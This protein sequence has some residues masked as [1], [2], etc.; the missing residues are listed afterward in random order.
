MH[1]FIAAFFFCFVLGLPG[2]AGFLDV[3][4]T[5][6]HYA[7]V[8]DLLKAGLITIPAD[9]RFNGVA[10]LTRYQMAY[11]FNRFL[12]D[13]DNPWQ[14]TTSLITDFYSDLKPVHA[15]YQTVKNLVE[16]GVLPGSGRF[17]GEAQVTR[18]EFYSYFALLLETKEGKPLPLAAPGSGFTDVLPSNSHYNYLRK[19][20]G[21]GLLSGQGLFLGERTVNRYEMADFIAPL[22]VSQS[23]PNQS[24]Q[25]PPAEGPG[26]LEELKVT[27]ILSNSLIVGDDLITRYDLAD[28]SSMI[29]ERILLDE[30]QSLP[31]AAPAQAYKD[32]PPGHQAYAA[33]QK[34]IAAGVVPPGNR[35]E[36]FYGDRHISRYQMVYFV[37]SAL[38]YVLGGAGNFPSAAA[39]LGYK[40]VINS[41][42]VYPTI[43]KLIGLGILAGGRENNFSG[44]DYVDFDELAYFTVATVKAIEARLTEQAKAVEY[45]PLPDF[46]FRLSS[47]TQVGASQTTGGAADGSDLLDLYGH[48]AIS[49]IIDR[50]ISQQASAFVSLTGDYYFGSQAANASPYFDSAYVSL[51]NE[52]FTLQVG[53]NAYYQ[54]FTP[55]GNS[56]FLDLVS[57]DMVVG[58]LAGEYGTATSLL[59]KMSYTG[60]VK[61]D[62][63]FG[64]L[65]L[66]PTLPTP[67]DWTEVVLGAS[68]V[69]N[70]P[71]PTLTTSLGSKV[72]QLYGGLR[73]NLFDL[74]TL[75]LEQAN[76]NFS[77]PAVLGVIGSSSQE[78][79]SATQYSISYYSEDYGYSL[80]LGYQDLGDDYYVGT[81]ASPARF[82]G[83]EAGTS[84][85]LFQTRCFPQPGQTLGFDVAYIKSSGEYCST[86][87][88]GLYETELAKSSYLNVA[89]TKVLSTT[90]GVPESLGL[91]TSLLLYF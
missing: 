1:K 46:G 55:F 33:V 12:T 27:G 83:A 89:L 73:F 20:V 8:V 47:N 58:Q 62:A 61:Q 18:Y 63:N 90:S 43:Q 6:P 67:L 26:P 70:L 77:D 86:G 39:E 11:V 59:G 80:S 34:L 4:A 82:L 48:Q 53:R 72:T 71:D 29:L 60:N 52:P 25:R 40:D 15:A 68:L 41:N 3:P 36:L 64:S 65:V 30:K 91:T 69:T 88:C 42:Y 87:F 10:A 24:S 56:L 84:S 50:N 78:G 79:L 57:T 23:D 16:A 37:F 9:Q 49:L 45:T 17:D 35:R 13:K 14:K 21:A 22:L 66:A 7:A 54:G 38:E 44:N 31:L 75:T 28:L 51:K 81:L 5:S 19:L 2:W 85:W 32:V 76:L 74:L